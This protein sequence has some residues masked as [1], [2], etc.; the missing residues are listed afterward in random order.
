MRRFRGLGVALVVLAMSAGVVLAAAP[1]AQPSTSNKPSAEAPSWVTRMPARLPRP[2]PPRA[3][4]RSPKPRRVRRRRRPTPRTSRTPRRVDNGDTHGALVSAAAQMVTPAGFR[5]HGAFVSC[6]AHLKDATLATIDWTTVTPEACAAAKGNKGKDDTAGGNATRPPIRPSARRRKTPRRQ[7]GTPP[8][9]RRRPP[10]GTDRTAPARAGAGQPGT[11]V[12][13]GRC[14]RSARR[15]SRS[16][17]GA[18]R[19]S[20]TWRGWRGPSADRVQDVLGADHAEELLDRLVELLL[21]GDQVSSAIGK[22][23]RARLSQ[24]SSATSAATGRPG[25]ASSAFLALDRRS[26]PCGGPRSS[27]GA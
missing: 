16:R 4:R 15:R 12:T 1:L 8:R 14:P 20:G 5:N 23:T 10:R 21:R 11:R 26:A 13:S 18:S 22:P 19:S 24:P 9:P 17:A 27:R 6:V 2:R 3:R 25:A 7:P